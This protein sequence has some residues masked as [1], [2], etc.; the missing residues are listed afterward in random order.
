[1]HACAVGCIGAQ[2][3]G[4]PKI[5][6]PG[7]GGLDGAKGT[8]KHSRINGI[9]ATSGYHLHS[10]AKCGY[11][12]RQ[13]DRHN[14]VPHTAEGD[15]MNNSTAMAPELL[16]IEAAWHAGVKA[17]KDD[18]AGVYVFRGSMQAAE[19]AGYKRDNEEGVYPS[20]GYRVFTTAYLSALNEDYPRGVPCNAEGFVVE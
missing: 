5:R 4:G 7:G 15:D 10:A 1:V 16:N 19:D 17:W 8:A 12:Y 14:P 9:D 6:G 18:K 11:T 20:L 3:P 13:Q 2:V